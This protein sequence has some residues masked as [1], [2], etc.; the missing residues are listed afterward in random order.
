MTDTDTD[1]TVH[2]HG[3][4]RRDVGPV[5]LLFAGIGS[6]IGSGWLFGAFTASGL[7]GPA[8]LLSWVIAG[9][10]ILLIALCYAELGPMFPITGGVVRY[11]HLVWGSFASYSLG[12]ITWISAAAVPAIEVEGALQYATRYADFTTK[13]V[14]HGE[15]TYTLTPLGLAAAILLLAVFVVVNYYGVRLF[16]QI[17]NVLVWWKLAIVVLVIATFLILA[18]A[19]HNS[20]GGTANYTSHGFAPY[21]SHGVFIAISTAGITFSFLGFR[22]GIE[23]A[24]ESSN[25]RRN[26]PIAV[27]GSVLITGLLYVLLQVAFTMGVPAPALAKSGSWQN[28]SFTNDFGPLAAISS[29]AGA[30]WLAYLLYADAIISPADTGFIYTTVSSRISYAMGRNRNAPSVFARTNSAGVPVA[31][32]FLTFVV[33]I[34]LFLPFPS[35]QQLVGFITSATVIS[36]GSGPLVLTRVAPRAGRPAATVPALRR[37]TDPVPRLLQLQHD[38]VLG[39][40]VGEQ[41]AVHHRPDR[42]RRAGGLP[43]H[44]RPF[45][46]AGAGLAGRFLGA[47]LVRRHG[48]D[49]LAGRPQL[50][51]GRVQLGVPDQPGVLRGH[52]P[53][54]GVGAPTPCRDRSPHRRRRARVERG[55]VERDARRTEFRPGRRSAGAVG[56]GDRRPAVGVAIHLMAA[57]EHPL[58]AVQHVERVAG[59][60]HHVAVLALGQ[61]T[62][63]VVEAED[64]APG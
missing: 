15:K 50:A 62:D 37:P 39:R 61:R 49:Q 44:R 4:L 56:I 19:G 46:Q 45:G 3:K 13:H 60:H 38:R 7:A 14:V 40:L 6:I 20:M 21:G 8:A 57:D 36:F 27:I 58:G 32:L 17:N 1:T 52:L 22:Q 53:A 34:V 41:E 43:F 25:P 9:F 47:A 2:S 11:P 12:W 23:L 31:G 24:G 5:G 29:L 26:I 16:S 30:T 63:P 33:G 35:W 64:A 54:R 48:A 28:L 51:S 10:M 59:P 18:F 55:G 42:L